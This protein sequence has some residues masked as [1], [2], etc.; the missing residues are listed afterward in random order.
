MPLPI[1]T[2]KLVDQKIQMFCD[3]RVPRHVR[4]KLKLTHKFRGNSV[5]IYEERAPW[6]EDMKEWTSHPFAQMRYD[7]KTGKWSLFCADRN[8][9]WHKYIGL[10]PSKDIDLMLNEID[11]DP[12]MIFW[13]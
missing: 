12:T 4:N 2:I 10:K 13:G 6:R 3:N 8:G 9:K 5:T 7:E 1:F 11:R